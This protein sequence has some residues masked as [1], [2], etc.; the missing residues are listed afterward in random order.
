MDGDNVQYFVSMTSDL[1]IFK[2]PVG[3]FQ[4]GRAHSHKAAC[5]I[6]G[7]QYRP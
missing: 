6:T 7:T 5:V 4:A 1:F 2:P 3:V